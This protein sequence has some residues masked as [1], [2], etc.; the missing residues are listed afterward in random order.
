VDD[1][2]ASVVVGEEA[3]KCDIEWTS[4]V[5]A[6]SSES[7]RDRE[8]ERDRIECVIELNFTSDIQSR[9]HHCRIDIYCYNSRTLTSSVLHRR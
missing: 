1:R 5:H 9:V 8:R 4:K 2:E 3:L 6:A 7:V